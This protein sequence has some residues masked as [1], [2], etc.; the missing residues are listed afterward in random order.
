MPIIRKINISGT[1]AII[2]EHLEIK[3]IHFSL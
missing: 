3:E 2:P 1:F